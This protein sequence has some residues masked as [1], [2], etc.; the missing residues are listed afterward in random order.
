M[1]AT[2]NELYNI[3]KKLIGNFIYNMIFNKPNTEVLL[4]C[5][6]SYDI[7]KITQLFNNKIQCKYI[8]KYV[9]DI[10]DL[11]ELE[12]SI[13]EDIHII[14][15][16]RHAISLN[17]FRN[18]HL[19]ILVINVI[20]PGIIE[21]VFSSINEYPKE[22]NISINLKY[23]FYLEQRSLQNYITMNSAELL[24]NLFFI[25]ERTRHNKFQ[26]TEESITEIL[27]YKPIKLKMWLQQMKN[28][29]Y[30]LQECKILTARL[31]IVLYRIANLDSSISEKAI[32]TYIS[33]IFGI[34]STQKSSA[35][36]SISQCK[37]YN[38]NNSVLFNSQC[39]QVSQVSYNV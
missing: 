25:F 39:I 5:G 37:V 27:M 24:K 34:T 12:Y 1:I 9:N 33:K 11:N 15:I 13:D 26:F 35:R 19:K 4:L 29:I 14:L 36:F 3:N 21:D 30:Y 22:I 2:N 28:H 38:L 17:I 10:K 18:T 6:I 16:A 23:R 20:Y 32:G 31:A 8:I 7:T